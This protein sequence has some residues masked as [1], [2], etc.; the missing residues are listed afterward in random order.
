MNT[1]KDILNAFKLI[2]SYLR[3]TRYIDFD[4]SFLRSIYKQFKKTKVLSKKQEYG[5]ANIEAL[6]IRLKS[7]PKPN[8]N[9]YNSYLRKQGDNYKWGDDILQDDGFGGAIET[10]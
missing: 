9:K 8:H 1:E 2:Y 3:K 10:W 7:N 5:L 4:R 6:V